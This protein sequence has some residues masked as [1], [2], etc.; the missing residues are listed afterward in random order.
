M[1]KLSFWGCGSLLLVGVAAQAASPVG[2]DRIAV[3][4]G[5]WHNRVEHYATPYGKAGT[6]TTTLRN[7]CWR[8]RAF[9][10]CEQVVDGKPVALVVFVYDIAKHSYIT[11]PIP[12]DGS[13]AGNGTLLIDGETWT[14]PW[15]FA[16]HG[17]TVY[18]RVV[19]VF[20]GR[21]RIDYRQEYS[22]DQTHWTAMARGVETRQR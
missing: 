5:T 13:A 10:A 20:H 18:A 11:H 2:L 1:R 19:N 16:D 9:Y 22:L 6:E 4:A 12:A 14:F 15:Q 8:A 21:D 17:K 7:D 3:Y